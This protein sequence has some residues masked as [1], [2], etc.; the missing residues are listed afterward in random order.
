VQ[1]V[2]LAALFLSSAMP[3]A[4]QSERPIV[5]FGRTGLNGTAQCYD[6]TV[7]WS[8]PESFT[9]SGQTELVVTDADGNELVHHTEQWGG[10]TPLRPV[11]CGDVLQDGS[12][13]FA[14]TYYTGGAGGCCDITY[15]VLL[16][17]GERILDGYFGYADPIA[18]GDGPLPLR[19]GIWLW[20]AGISHASV[21]VLPRYLRFEDG[22]YLDA[23]R[24]FPNDLR[25]TLA[26]TNS[27]LNDWL[28]RPA[29]GG[30]ESRR[31]EAIMAYAL[32]SLLDEGDAWL[33]AWSPRLPAVDRE[34]L[35]T[36]RPWLATFLADT[37]R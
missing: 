33:T 37:F 16:P 11:W 26:D 36:Q 21:G 1:Y 10:I 28:S 5:S 32:A 22:A 14:Y 8:S 3:A 2:L 24:S 17:G 18:G 19:S 7:T 12:L 15:I 35:E 20:P 13:A 34:W 6:Y 9:S 31:E 23:T 27:A 29:Y 4:A 30:D 25:A